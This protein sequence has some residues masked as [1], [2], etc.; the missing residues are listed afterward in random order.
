MNLEIH[1]P[2]LEER[3]RAQ[4]Q[5]GHFQ[6]TDELL[7]KALDALEEK[8]TMSTVSAPAAPYQRPPG[9]KSL[10]ELFEDSP[11]KGL[12]L[13]FSRSRTSSRAVDLA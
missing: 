8:E 5:S 4:I 7:T 11:W 3:V 6:N 10:V 2:A 1:T 12:D 9:C 13:D